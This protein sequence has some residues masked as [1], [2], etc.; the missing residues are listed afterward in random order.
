MIEDAVSIPATHVHLPEDDI[1]LIAGIV[2]VLAGVA[3]LTYVTLSY[4]LPLMQFLLA[5][6]LPSTLSPDVIVPAVV[7]V[8]LKLAGA[9]VLVWPGMYL[10]RK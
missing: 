8:V 5:F 4:T 3:L 9:A 6:S 1:A 7:S 10:L 2:R